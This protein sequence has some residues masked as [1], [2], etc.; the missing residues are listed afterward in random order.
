[1]A[2]II[3]ATVPT[4]DTPNPGQVSIYAKANLKLYY[5]DETGAEFEIIS[6]GSA[7]SGYNVDYFTISPGEEIAKQI[8]LS[9]TPTDPSKTLVDIYGGGGVQ[10]YSIDYTVSGDI[11]SWSGLRLD[12]V[13][14]SGDEI[15]VVWS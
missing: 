5:K 4:L 12:G 8:Q 10:I 14:S 15:R 9:G 1:M 13:I 3:L 7:F 2:R 11:L 6:S